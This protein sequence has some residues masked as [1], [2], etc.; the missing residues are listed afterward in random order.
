M[1]LHP[2]ARCLRC[3]MPPASS[4]YEE[5]DGESRPFSRLIL[6]LKNQADHQ[7]CEDGG[8]DAACGGFQS[9]GEWKSAAL[10]TGPEGGLEEKEVE[11]AMAAGWKVCTLGRRILRCETAPLCALSAIMYAAGEF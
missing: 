10:L 1:R 2:S 6:L 5:R 11:K 9:A 8:G 3:C 7:A 4:E